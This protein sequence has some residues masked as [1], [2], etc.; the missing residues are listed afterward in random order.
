V[1]E[2]KHIP[3]NYTSCPCQECVSYRERQELDRLRAKHLEN[4]LGPNW[5]NILSGMGDQ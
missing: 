2:I 5:K 3:F 1:T 4:K